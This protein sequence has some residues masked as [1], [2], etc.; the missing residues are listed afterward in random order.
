MLSVIWDGSPLVSHRVLYDICLRV[1][2]HMAFNT[3]D[4]CGICMNKVF[5]HSVIYSLPGEGVIG[6]V[7]STGKHFP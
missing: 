6:E 5:S 3:G 2:I 1:S 7:S 4:V